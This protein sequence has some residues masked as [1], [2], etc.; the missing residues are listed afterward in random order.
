MGFRKCGSNNVPES[1]REVFFKE[2]RSG[3]SQSAAATV[4][5]V[6]HQ[7]GSQWAR[8]AGIPADLQHRGVRYPAV[9][10]EA[11]WA[12][13]RSGA[14]TIEAAV[15]AGV[16]ERFFPAAHRLKP[17]DVVQNFEETVVLEMDL[18]LEAAAAPAAVPA[19]QRTKRKKQVPRGNTKHKKDLRRE[20]YASAARVATIF[21]LKGEE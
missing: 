3:S 12:A 6:S 2:L 20:R 11:F 8:A 10:R 5:G 9:V 19:A 18:R 21:M 14:S 17:R 15:I 4:A 1:A 16:I 7:T 13:M